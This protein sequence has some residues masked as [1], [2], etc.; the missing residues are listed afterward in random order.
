MQVP[1]F[2]VNGDGSFIPSVP[3]EQGVAWLCGSSF[4]RGDT[5]LHARDADQQANLDRLRRLLPRVAS[6]LE[7]VATLRAWTGI[8]C[9]SND[10]RPLVGALD[11]DGQEGLWL[12]TAMGS[13]GLTF[14]ALCGELIAAQLHGEPLPLARNLARALSATRRQKA[15]ASRSNA[16]E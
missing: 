3:T 11:G 16:G 6:Q 7:A 4:E 13:R 9:A 10:R 14:A 8:R 15:A 2:P 1:P 5:D 12:S